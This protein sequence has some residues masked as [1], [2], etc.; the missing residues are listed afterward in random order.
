MLYCVPPQRST[1]TKKS[2]VST[3]FELEPKWIREN[4]L[5]LIGARF[6]R[7]Q[8]GRHPLTIMLHFALMH[9]NRQF[10]HLYNFMWLS[11][12][13]YPRCRVDVCHNMPEYDTSEGDDATR[14]TST[15]QRAQQWPTAKGGRET[16]ERDDVC[17]YVCNSNATCPKLAL[18]PEASLGRT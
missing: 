1:T 13:R 10:C 17:D 5:R 2:Q 12:F 16:S 4:P 8:G 6:L 7:Q 18:R 9:V 11:S 3:K 14:R 15:S